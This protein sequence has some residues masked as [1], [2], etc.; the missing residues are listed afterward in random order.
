MASS[1]TAAAASSREIAD[2]L[3]PTRAKSPWERS[4]PCFGDSIP[5]SL[6]LSTACKT[7]RVVAC[8]A[9]AT[10]RR[11]GES[12]ASSSGPATRRGVT[13]SSLASAIPRD[14][15]DDALERI[16]LARDDLLERGHELGCDRDTASGSKWVPAQR[17]SSVIAAET[18]VG[19]R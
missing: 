13:A 16:G 14:R 2:S 18:V 9:R 17:R 5:R 11:R 1:L 8:A 4:Y 6:A 3:S 7:A 12:R 19:F 10:G 15:D